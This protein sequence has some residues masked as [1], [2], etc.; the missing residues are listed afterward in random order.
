[1]LSL[2][3]PTLSCTVE[4]AG[5]DALAGMWPLVV[6]NVLA[7]PLMQMAPALAARVARGGRLVLSGIRTS[8]ASDVEKSYTRR[9][10]T[11]ARSASRDGWT[12]LTLAATW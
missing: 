9:G 10:M 8:L 11:L 6:A 5:P 3:Q 4:Q 7:A 1:M 12:A 2:P